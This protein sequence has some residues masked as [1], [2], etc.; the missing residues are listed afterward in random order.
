MMLQKVF[1]FIH[2]N[3]EELSVVGSGSGAIGLWWLEVAFAMK[4]LVSVLTAIYI[5]IKIYKQL[6]G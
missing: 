2:E 5:S 4:L 6:K 3:K 1:H